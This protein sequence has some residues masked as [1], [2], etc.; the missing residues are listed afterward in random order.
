LDYEDRPGIGEW[1]QTPEDRLT[2][3]L[4]LVRMLARKW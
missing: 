4:R 2:T 1:Q 3:Q